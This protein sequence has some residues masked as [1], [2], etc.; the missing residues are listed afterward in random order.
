MRYVLDICERVTKSHRVTIDTDRPID[1]ICDEI[2]TLNEIELEAL[3]KYCQDYGIFCLGLGD[4]KQPGG[5]IIYDDHAYE[6]G[7]EDCISIKGPYLMTSLRTLSQA[8]NDNANVLETLIDG[9]QQQIYDDYEKYINVGE[10]DNYLAKLISN[11]KPALVYAETA[12]RIVGDEITTDKTR[13]EKQLDLAIERAKDAKA[14]V[15]L[16]YDDSTK[17]RYQADKYQH[18]DNVILKNAN[19]ALGGEF[20]YAFVDIEADPTNLFGELQQLYMLTQRSQL[21]TCVLDSK[22]F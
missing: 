22:K 16:V 15:L 3:S 5:K 4:N 12:D 14:K 11:S 9:V 21:Y 2:E 8:K 13:F 17:S 18:N 6:S 20:M 19:Q 7:I 10:R 1:D